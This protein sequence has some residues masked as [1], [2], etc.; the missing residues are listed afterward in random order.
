VSKP[1]VIVRE[2]PD[3]VNRIG[4][5]VTV[6]VNV[7]RNVGLQVGIGGH[8][9]VDLAVGFADEVSLTAVAGVGVGLNVAVVGSTPCSVAESIAESVAR[10]PKDADK[11]KAYNL[12]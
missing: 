6:G 12:A 11:H 2:A 10:L 3:A 4:D 5:G 9:S 1:N 8:V 7:R